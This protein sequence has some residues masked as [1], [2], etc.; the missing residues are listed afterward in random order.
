MDDVT[1]ATGTLDTD[2]GTADSTWETDMGAAGAAL[3]RLW[4]ESQTLTGRT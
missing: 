1:A 3:G 2:L 4:T